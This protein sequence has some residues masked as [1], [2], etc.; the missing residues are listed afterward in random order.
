MEG[1]LAVWLTRSHPHALSLE[2]KHGRPLVRGPT[3]QKERDVSAKNVVAAEEDGNENLSIEQ[4]L[5]ITR[6]FYT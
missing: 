3:Y 6:F 2:T 1:T 5:L 4:L